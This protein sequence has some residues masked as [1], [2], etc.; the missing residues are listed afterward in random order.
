LRMGRIAAKTI[1]DRIEGN[2]DY[3]PEIVIEPELIVRSS[4]GPAN[5]SSAR[6]SAVLT[7]QSNL[8]HSQGSTD[9]RSDQS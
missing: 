7:A 4:S 2:S 9:I 1:I 5:G 8:E 6:N 3:V